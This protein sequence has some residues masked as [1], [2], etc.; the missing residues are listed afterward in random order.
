MRKDEIIIYT[1]GSSIGNP[2]AGGWGSV[3]A[4]N[5]QKIIEIGGREEESTNNRMEMTAAIEALKLIEKRKIESKKIIIHT[6][7]SYLLNGITMWIFAW[8]K[9]EWKTKSGDQVLNKD[10]WEILYKVYLNLKSNFE[11]E[12]VKVAGHGGIDLN[13]RC[14]EIAVGFSSQTRPVLFTGSLKDY[15]RLFGISLEDHKKKN[16]KITKDKKI[17]SFKKGIAYSYVSYVSGKINV[18]KTWADCE[19][20][21]K[22]KASAKYKKVYDK[23]EEQE[24]IGLWSLKSL[25]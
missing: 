17:K 8:V 3:V 6:D 14:D 25:L 1:D 9:N 20:R 2:G 11:I 4:I 16:S 24:L 18:D 13:E 5:N 15:E 10:L 7:S 12:W 19:K 22:G 23:Q 21:V